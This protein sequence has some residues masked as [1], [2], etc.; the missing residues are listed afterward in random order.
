MTHFKEFQLFKVILQFVQFAKELE[1]HIKM[2]YPLSEGYILACFTKKELPNQGNFTYEG[3]DF[4]WRIHG[5]GITYHYK[6]F[7]FHYDM[8]SYGGGGGRVTFHCLTLNDFIKDNN[9]EV[10][11]APEETEILLRNLRDRMLIQQIIPEY[12]VYS[13]V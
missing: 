6:N 8:N 1:F 2:E 13:L 7:R 3:N 4:F 10:S 11:F 9:K 5:M 12:E